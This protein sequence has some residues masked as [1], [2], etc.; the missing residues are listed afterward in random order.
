[1]RLESLR[2]PTRCAGCG[3]AVSAPARPG[4]ASFWDAARFPNWLQSGQ[5]TGTHLFPGGW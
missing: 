2:T 4:H 3:A 5:R 1:M